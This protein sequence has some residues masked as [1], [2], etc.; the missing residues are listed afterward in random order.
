MEVE[1]ESLPLAVLR[2]IVTC[3]FLSQGILGGS[4]AES[5][6]S[7]SQSRSAVAHG[8]QIEVAGRRCASS[9][10]HLGPGF[11]G[12]YVRLVHWW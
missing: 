5:C 4:F 9:Q 7:L 12:G 2:A 1:C 11:P 10:K 3:S 6:C 8:S